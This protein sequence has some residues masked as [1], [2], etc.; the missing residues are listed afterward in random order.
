MTASVDGAGETFEYLRF[1]AKWKSIEKNIKSEK[2]V[3]TNG[4]FDI[5][6]SGHIELLKYA[7]L[8]GKKF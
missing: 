2:I 4:V 6:H 5:L 7:K 1:P 8:L 3:F